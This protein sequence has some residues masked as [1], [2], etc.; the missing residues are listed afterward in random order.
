MS[1]LTIETPTSYVHLSL[2]EAEDYYRDG[3]MSEEHRE[4]VKAMHEGRHWEPGDGKD[5]AE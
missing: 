1:A 3:Q 4:M 5:A 2:Q